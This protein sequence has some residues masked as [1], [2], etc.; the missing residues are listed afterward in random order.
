MV[1]GEE[2]VT[3]PETKISLLETIVFRGYVS[4]RECS[5]FWLIEK[6]E[7]NNMCFF[8]QSPEYS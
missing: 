6:N 4:F 1:E 5:C 2:A 3:L 7:T 8:E